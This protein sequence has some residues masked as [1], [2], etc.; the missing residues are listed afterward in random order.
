MNHQTWLEAAEIYSLGALEGEELLSFEEHWQTCADCR[1]RVQETRK[2]LSQLP[3][4]LKEVQPPASAKIALLKKIGSAPTIAA[5]RPYKMKA[6]VGITVLLAAFFVALP[7]WFKTPT[8]NPPAQTGSLHDASMETL[9]SAPEINLVEFKNL[10]TGEK[11]TAKLYWNPKACGG[12]F[13]IRGIKELEAGKVYE[14]WA[15]AGD[16]P[17][18]GGTFTVD[19]AGNAHLD[20]RGLREKLSFEKFAITIEPA[21]G[22]LTPTGPMQFLSL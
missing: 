7:S 22:S 16:K 15:L 3:Y 17:V 1:T 9:L 11:S 6:A 13:T 4:S 8:Q 21:G 10:S 18:P 19:K 12:C 20:I 5:S 2:L 14:L